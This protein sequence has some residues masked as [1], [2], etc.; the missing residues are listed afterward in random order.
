MWVRY[1]GKT[2]TG[3]C[4]LCI[5][6]WKRSCGHILNFGKPRKWLHVC[7]QKKK[8][9]RNKLLVSSVLRQNDRQWRER[10]F[11]FLQNI[12]WEFPNCVC[13]I[14]QY[15][16]VEWKISRTFLCFSYFFLLTHHHHHHHH[17]SFL[18]FQRKRGRDKVRDNL[19]RGRVL[20]L[21]VCVLW[22]PFK[23]TF[24]HC[25]VFCYVQRYREVNRETLKMTRRKKGIVLHLS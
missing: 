23:T 1:V 25:L 3:G 10:G 12:L 5:S 20:S 14:P 2:K 4:C 7:V 18:H 9:V 21:M 17:P 19:C 13:G 24:S 6:T 16:I 8:R 11:C 15:G 22:P